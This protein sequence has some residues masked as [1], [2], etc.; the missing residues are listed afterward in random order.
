MKTPSIYQ[1]DEREKDMVDRTEKAAIGAVSFK[2]YKSFFKAVN[3]SFYVAIVALFFI[4]AQLTISGSDYFVS[5]WAIWEESVANRTAAIGCSGNDATIAMVINTNATTASMKNISENTINE[6]TIS[7]EPISIVEKRDRFMMLY[8]I[9]MVVG[10]CIYIYRCFSFFCLCLR[11]SINMH[12]KLFRGISRA[13]MVFFNL[14]SSGR[15]LNRFARDICSVD[16]AL[17][18]VLI[19]VIDV[20]LES[21]FRAS[22]IFVFNRN[23]I[24]VF[25]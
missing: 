2:I 23:K 20:S 16:S 21:S 19:D 8:A 15:I 4:L 3:S 25:S 11:V 22:H 6:I 7:T 12:D 5:Q 10:T 14:N 1:E 17:P 18:L 24:S 13:Q 9:I